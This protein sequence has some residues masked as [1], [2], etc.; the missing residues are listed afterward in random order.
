MAIPNT[1][2]RVFEYK[3][4]PNKSFVLACENVLTQ[5]QRLYNAC[6]E[7][8]ISYYQY[9]GKTI[10]WIY[11]ARELTELREVEP[12]QRLIPRDIQT[13]VLKRLDKA[14]QAFFRRVRTGEKAGFPRFRSRDRY[15]S[16][17]YAINQRHSCA[18]IGNKLRVAGIGTT[19]LTIT[20]PIQG[21]IKVIRIIKRANGWFAQ[22]VCAVPKSEALPKAGESIGLDMGLEKF[23]TLSNGE[24]I[25]NPRFGKKAQETIANSQ[26]IL[27]RKRKG[28]NSRNKAKRV[29]A[30]AH[31]KIVSQ[32]KDFAFKEVNKLVKRFD[33]I[34]IEKLNVKGLAQ[35]NLAKSINDAAWSTFINI[36]RFK[37]EW[38]GREVVEVPAQYTSQDCSS[39]GHRQKLEL[40]DRV[41]S[42]PK[43]GLVLNRDHN[44]A[45]N[46]LGRGASLLAEK[47]TRRAISGVRGEAQD[48]PSLRLSLA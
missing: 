13:E 34:A 31:A 28:S 36:L 2:T 23:A 24:Q 7:Q 20:R 44:A 33:V 8:R 25:E 6:L 46:I 11:Q 9:Q 37:A 43:C 15:N 41:Y 38:A 30:K 1:I 35:S 40:K 16:F 17:E 18:L 32:R 27:A 39:C 29:V 19:R 45:I 21:Q 42:C 3:I 12:S 22:L 10:N 48:V 14:Y 47:L 4:R 5:C 26:R